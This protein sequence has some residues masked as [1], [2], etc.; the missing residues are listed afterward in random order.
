MTDCEDPA[1]LFCTAGRVRK[2]AEEAAAARG[3]TDPAMM[4]IV[5]IES[6]ITLAI[7]N[8]VDRQS[9]FGIF[10]AQES[11]LREHIDAVRR[12]GSEARA[13]MH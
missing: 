1:C 2:I 9:L 3:W 6:A 4:L 5:A 13:G 10:L 7:A 12:E 8:G 11:A